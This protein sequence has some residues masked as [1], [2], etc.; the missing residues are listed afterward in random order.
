[1]KQIQ[2]YVWTTMVYILLFELLIIQV[3]AL[4]TLFEAM[5]TSPG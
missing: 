2:G 5:G 1:M 4:T 3:E